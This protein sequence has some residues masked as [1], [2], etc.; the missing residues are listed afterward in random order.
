MVW[1]WP[2]SLSH[3]HTLSLTHSLTHS[4]SLPSHI[5]VH[6]H[7]HYVHQN[8]PFSTAPPPTH[9]E[10]ESVN[11][12][13]RVSWQD[14]EGSPSGEVRPPFP[15]FSC[16][17]R[18]LALKLCGW[19][20]GND[21]QSLEDYLKRYNPCQFLPKKVDICMRCWQCT[22][23]WMLLLK[24]WT[25]SYGPRVNINFLCFC[26]CGLGRSLLTTTREQL[27]LLYSKVASDEG[28]HHWRTGQEL[29]S[30]KET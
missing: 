11:I 6:V 9:A 19:S 3:T 27:P 21:G 25:T 10:G 18:Q 1:T 12:S 13:K 2:P 8:N 30:N 29:P 26:G 16:S 22:R 24:H 5:P 17:E 20:F 23:C 15:M 14:R 7:A 4:L 28:L